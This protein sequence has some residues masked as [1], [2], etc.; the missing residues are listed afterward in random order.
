MVNVIIE[1]AEALIAAACVCC[2]K[3]ARLRDTAR[4]IRSESL[5]LK[6]RANVV[7][8]GR[9]LRGGSHHDETAIAALAAPI[10]AVIV[11]RPTCLLC[12]A[13]AVGAAELAVLRSLQHIS[14]TVDMTTAQQPCAACGRMLGP[15]YSLARG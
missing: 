6:V 11:E 13:G 7:R 4:A 9:T 15:V 10:V 2:G 8:G 5:M 14:V 12:I 1:R 3:A